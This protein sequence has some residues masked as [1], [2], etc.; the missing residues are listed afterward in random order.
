MESRS[1]IV[2]LSTLMLVAKNEWSSILK[3][4]MTDKE[5]LAMAKVVVRIS[6]DI[7][8]EVTA[9]IGGKINTVF[10]DMYKDN[11]KKVA[12]DCELPAHFVDIMIQCQKTFLNTIKGFIINSKLKV[13]SMEEAK[14]YKKKQDA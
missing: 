11:V 1:R 8:E 4:D 9:A 2:N 14:E 7:V 10:Y 5:I 3:R 13:I 12:I 6:H